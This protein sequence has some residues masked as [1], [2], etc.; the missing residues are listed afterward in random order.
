MYTRVREQ[1]IPDGRFKSPG[2]VCCPGDLKRPSGI[3]CSRA[4]IHPYLLVHVANVLNLV[5][6]Y[7]LNLVSKRIF[8]LAQTGR[9]WVRWKRPKLPIL[10]E[11]PYSSLTCSWHRPAGGPWMPQPTAT[12]INCWFPALAVVSGPAKRD[13]GGPLEASGEEA[14]FMSVPMQ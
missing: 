3:S 1:E 6:Y 8:N 4:S 2:A 14:E 12:V 5:C 10:Q 13:C 9:C 7:V 11:W